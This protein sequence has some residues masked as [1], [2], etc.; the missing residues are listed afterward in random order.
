MAESKPRKSKVNKASVTEDVSRFRL[1]ELGYSGLKITSGVAQEEI[2]KELNFPN[3]II[4]YKQMSYHSVIAAALALYEIMCS[5]VE[6]KVVEP[7]N[8]TEE[9]KRRT[10]IIKECMHDMEHSWLEFM[11]EVV[12]AKTY[13][14]AVHEKVYRRRL[15]ANGS[16]YDDGLI[17]WKKLAPRSQD[18]IDKFLFDKD[19]RELIG[20]KQNLSLVQDGYARF[21]TLTNGK[22]ITIPRTKFMLF[23]TGKHRGNPFG[24]SALRDCYFSWKFLTQIEEIEA[25]GVARDL[26]G[27]PIL[28]IPASYMTSDATEQQKQIFA[29]YQNAMRNIQNNQQASVILPSEV[30]PDTKTPLFELDLL[31]TEGKKN[32]NTESIINYHKNNILTALFADIL[33]MGQNTTGSYALGNLKANLM[34]VAVEAFLREVQ[35]V[36]N[37]DLIRQTYELNGWDTTRTCRVIYDD[38]QEENLEEFSKLIQRVAS[39]GLIERDRAVLNKIRDAIGVEQYPADMPVQDELL[40]GNTSRSGDGMAT[41]GEGTSN[42]PSGED[43]SSNNLENAA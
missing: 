28:R 32:F 4:T 9:E 35:E 36:I 41:A 3:S 43:T 12:S 25:S 10:E 31:G 18:T 5:K 33:I 30:D 11:Q 16:K 40:T 8:A 21:S 13:G 42:S 29:Y 27:M 15:K 2:K 37:N 6:W 34:G 17:G 26:Q 14:F 39:V 1:G 38:F 19:G 7:L 24:R 23:R 22:E 20:V